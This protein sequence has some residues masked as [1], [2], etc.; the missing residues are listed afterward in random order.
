MPND[1]PLTSV[2]AIEAYSIPSELPM[3]VTSDVVIYPLMA[4]PLLLEDERAVKA[5]QAAIDAGHKV[6]AI[7]GELEESD[8]EEDIRR[9]S[10][11]PVGTAIYIARSAEMPDGRM[12]VLVQGMAR[13]SLVDVLQSQPHPIAQVEKVASDIEHNTELEA[14][15]RNIFGQFKKAVALAPNVP[16]EV[17]EALDALSEITH[18]ADFIASQLNVDFEEQQKILTEHNLYRR[19]EAINQCLNREVEILELRE[20]ISSEAAGSMEDAQKEYFLRQQLRAI[21]DELGEGEDIGAEIEELRE[22]IEAAGMSEEAKT[23]AERELKRMARMPEASAEYT[24]SRTYLDWLVELPWNKKTS[25]Q[26]DIKEAERVLNADHY[27]LEKPKER[28]LEYL[29]VR[30]LKDDMRGPILLLV[31]PPGTGKTSL[32]KSVAHALGAN[33]SE[34][35][36]AA[37]ATNRKLG[38]TAAPTSAHCPDASYRACDA[39]AQKIPY[40]C[41]MKSTNSAQTFAAT[42]PQHCW[43]SWTRR[44]TTPLWITTSTSPLTS[45]KSYS[46]PLPT[47]S[48]QSHRHSWTGWKYWK[49]RDIPKPKKWKSHADTWSNAR[50]QNTA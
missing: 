21:Q 2:N 38:D 47:R 34:C 50:Y 6:I 42:P 26:L 49:S 44:K 5:A 11:Y 24:V 33:L 17:G 20:K 48:T 1:K 9:E 29:S 27:G 43:K 18:K 10:L 46:S 16:R 40:L 13:L 41:W 32:G 45:Q 12:Q 36:W 25:D 35:H 19:L 15:A 28:I 23:E 37:S 31:G 22:K 3:L 39:P 7:F 30:Q 8:A 14:L 4:A